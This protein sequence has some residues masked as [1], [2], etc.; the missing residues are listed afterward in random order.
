MKIFNPYRHGKKMSQRE[1]MRWKMEKIR[2]WHHAYKWYNTEDK[3][4][5]ITY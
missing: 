3:N 1:R 4:L 2:C 5:P